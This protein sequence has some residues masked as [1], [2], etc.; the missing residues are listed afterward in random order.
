[1]KA[2]LLHS[3][4]PVD[5]KPLQFSE[6]QLPAIRDDEVLVRVNACGICRTDLHLVEGDLAVRRSPI[7][8]GHQIVGRVA[9]LGAQVVEFAI[10]QR[11]GIAW[12]HHTCGECRFC[13]AGRENLCER[14]DF[15]G[16]TVNGGYAEYVIA[17]AR[18]SYPLPDGF[19]DL[20]AAPLLCA[21]II[22]YRSLRLTGIDSSA[23]PS[24]RLGIYGFGAAVHVVIQLARARGAEVYV[25]TRDRE[26]HQTLASELGATWVG[27]AMDEPPD[28][29]DASI[30]FAPAGE[31]V[32]VALK[33]L[34]KG[35]VLVLGGIHMSPIPSF[36]YPLIYGERAVRSVANNTREDGREFLAE[37]ASIPVRTYTQTFPLEQANEALIALKHDAIRGAG[38]LVVDQG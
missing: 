33:A 36:E 35:G 4:A 31:L 16:W 9:A 15:T 1:M 38:V 32:P 6:A 30:I 11:I 25:C 26:R 12:L 5:T 19:D 10:E 23:W 8:P 21:G 34:A 18:Y 7:I 22:G 28:K 3:P 27:G 29:L 2:L 20:Q 37:A 17:S 14:A 13:R 24:S